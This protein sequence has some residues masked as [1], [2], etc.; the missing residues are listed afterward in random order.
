MVGFLKLKK[1]FLILKFFNFFLNFKIF[2]I[3]FLNSR[4]FTVWCRVRRGVIWSQKYKVNDVKLKQDK[5]H[6]QVFIEILTIAFLNA[7]VK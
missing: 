5:G 2:K 7:D 4:V 1:I 6:R 3:F